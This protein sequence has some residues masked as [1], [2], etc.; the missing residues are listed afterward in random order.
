M[1]TLSV[2]TLNLASRTVATV[3]K[4]KRDSLGLIEEELDDVVSAF[5]VVEE[6]KEGPV[7]E[8]GP[9]LE[10][11]ERGAHRLQA[12]N[13]QMVNNSAAQFGEIVQIRL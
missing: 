5:G 9:L 1:K 13:T 2:P 6:D 7:D 12:K 3:W 10:R 8:P 4:Q 11:L